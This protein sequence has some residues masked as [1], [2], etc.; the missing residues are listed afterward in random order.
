MNSIYRLYVGLSS[1]V[2]PKTIDGDQVIAWVARQVD[3]FTVLTTQGF[4]RGD[5]EDTLVFTIAHDDQHFVINLAYKLRAQLNQEG[6]GLE[7]NGAYHRLTYANDPLIY[8]TAKRP[9][10]Y[11]NFNVRVYSD[12]HTHRNWCRANDVDV[13]VFENFDGGGWN[14]F[15]FEFTSLENAKAFAIRFGIQDE[16][17]LWIETAQGKI[18]YIAI[19][20]LAGVGDS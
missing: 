2:K 10:L 1:D 9:Q 3:S 12:L 4:F 17:S 20:T 16:D 7:H 18:G 5:A 6:I 19:P 14:Y 8:E 13:R 15:I 11:P